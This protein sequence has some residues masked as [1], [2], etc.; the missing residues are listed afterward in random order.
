MEERAERTLCWLSARS[1]KF[2]LLG[3][4]FERSSRDGFVAVSTSEEHAAQSVANG[5]ACAFR[6]CLFGAR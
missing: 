5:V 6:Q 2:S 1:T 3:R 4:L